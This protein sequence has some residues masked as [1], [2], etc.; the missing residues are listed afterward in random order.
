[1]K[2]LAIAASAVVAILGAP[3]AASAATVSELV[4][5]CAPHVAPRT[6]LA[7]I[8]VESKGSWWAVNDNDLETPRLATPADAIAYARR[9]V[10][11]GGSID[12]GI[13]QLNSSHLRTMHLTVDEAFEPCTNI[14]MGMSVLQDAWGRS[15]RNWG[16]TRYALFKAFEAY[17]GGP[18]AWTSR[19]ASLRKRVEGYANTVWSRAEA[20]PF[21]GAVAPPAA[22]RIVAAVSRPAQSRRWRP[23]HGVQVF[24]QGG[25]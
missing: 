13:A 15:V 22:P 3:A 16:P 9:R 20:L 5:R 2:R 14:A 1:V 24:F 18:G 10:A 6:A 11:E 12:I 19:S 23:R 8:S 25:Q 17:N 21:V 4:Q 7:I